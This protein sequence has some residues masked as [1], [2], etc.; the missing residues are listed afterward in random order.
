MDLP[1]CT[2][3]VRV[4]QSESAHVLSVSREK[5]HSVVLKLPPPSSQMVRTDVCCLR[6]IQHITVQLYPR[7]QAVGEQSRNGNYSYA[8]FFCSSICILG[9]K[10]TRRLIKK[11]NNVLSILARS[12]TH[13]KSEDKCLKKYVFWGWTMKVW[14]LPTYFWIPFFPF[15]LSKY[16][17]GHI[18]TILFH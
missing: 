5:G 13:P 10:V 7:Q 3:K 2:D 1:S 11:H 8:C 14:H 9:L 15:S 18:I 12:T 4:C 17:V 16:G 6:E